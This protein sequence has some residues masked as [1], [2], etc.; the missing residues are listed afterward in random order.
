MGV[1]RNLSLCLVPLSR[2]SVPKGAEARERERELDGVTRDTALPREEVRRG[3]M[4]RA[5]TFTEGAQA[6]MMAMWFSRTDQIMAFAKVQG[7][8]DSSIRLVDVLKGG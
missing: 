4:R 2:S 5:M 8:E 1:G 6:T 7:T 3:K